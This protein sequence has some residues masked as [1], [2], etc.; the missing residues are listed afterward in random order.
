MK[1]IYYRTSFG[2][3]IIKFY[4]KLKLIEKG[5]FLSVVWGAHF[6]TPQ[7]I[8]FGCVVLGTDPS[9]GDGWIRAVSY[10]L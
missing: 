3:V 6:C 1:L 10:K 2:L 7:M 5:D 4:Q 9:S 8:E